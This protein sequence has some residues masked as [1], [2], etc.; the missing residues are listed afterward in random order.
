MRRLED[1]LEPIKKTAYLLLR[2]RGEPKAI[3]VLQGFNYWSWMKCLATLEGYCRLVSSIPITPDG[4]K[5]IVGGIGSIHIWDWEANTKQTLSLQGHSDEVNFFAFSSDR[6][7]II[8]GSWKDARIKV[9]N[10]QTGEILYSPI[11]EYSLGIHSM[12]VCSDEE[13][14]IIGCGRKGLIKV[15][16]WKTNQLQRVIEAH[17]GGFSV[18]VDI[19]PDGNTLISG[20]SD[21]IKIWNWRTGE[22]LQAQERSQK[23][24]HLAVNFQKDIIAS[25]NSGK[26]EIHDLWTG[27]LK[28]ILQS[29]NEIFSLALSLDGSTLISGCRRKIEIWNLETGKLLGVLEGHRDY[30]NCLAFD[31]NKQIIVSNGHR[32]GIKV[33][34]IK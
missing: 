11:K 20:G 10:S 9:W 21:T 31:V 7:K 18:E 30:I 33:W 8:G 27:Q 13:T 29:H 3:R 6:Q 32:D 1:R 15:W 24:Y 5:I 26:I 12:A 25:S 16:N 34:G 22:L 2:Q 23:V 19:S 17:P 14:V 28:L 4:K